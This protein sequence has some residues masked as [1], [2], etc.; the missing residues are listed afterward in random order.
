MVKGKGI[1][2]EASDEPTQ[3]SGNSLEGSGLSNL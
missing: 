2:K 3:S 1:I